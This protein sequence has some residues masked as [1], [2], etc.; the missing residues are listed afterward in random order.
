MKPE[1]LV[2]AAGMGSRYGG[3][4]QLEPVGPYGEKIMD[5][6]LYDAKRSGIERVVFIIRREFEKEFHQQ[7]GAR[8][9]KWMDVAYAFQEL[10]QLPKGFTVPK[11]RVKPWGTSH[12]VLAARGTIKNPFIAM[13]ADDFYGSKAF[14]AL[15]EWLS[16]PVQAGIERYATVGFQMSNTLS[17]HGTVARGVC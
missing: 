13:N 15:V 12:A 7:V 9:A 3:L 6:G 4:K 10:E 11:G 16:K 2:M 17:A 14:S 8:F 1:L 5:Y